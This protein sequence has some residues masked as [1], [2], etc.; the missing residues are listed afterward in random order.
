MEKIGQNNSFYV[1]PE[2]EGA[3]FMSRYPETTKMTWSVRKFHKEE[4]Y[5]SKKMESNVY[6][7]GDVVMVMV[8]KV[9]N[10][11]R[12]YTADNKFL[13]LYKGD[14]IVGTL[15]Y[16]YASDAFHANSIDLSN[17]HLLTNSG[18]IGTV[19][20]RHSETIEPTRLKLIGI[21]SDHKDFEPI[22]L[23]SALFKPGK[24]GLTYP[25]VIFVIGTGMNSGKTTTTARIGHS[26]VE[27]GLSVSLLKV[28]GSVAYRD[29]FE[30][31]STGA[32][33]TADFSDYGFPS[34]YMC[35]QE[36]LVGL[37]SRMLEDTLSSKPDVILVEIADGILQRETQLLLKSNLAKSTSVGVI[38]TAP[39][40]CSALTLVGKVK[41]L[42]YS[43]IAVSGII[44][45]SPLFVEEFATYDSTPVLDTNGNRHQFVDLI[46]RRLEIPVLV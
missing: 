37:Y 14:I 35:P 16:R 4:L 3:G 46:S 30:F 19:T 42:N 32:R 20:S 31:E 15:G 27:N 8:T 44:T 1:E 9:A 29:L 28:T 36:E 40:A 17:L 2:K 5:V 24:K 26:L 23:K 39:C 25:P 38:L 33:Y 21:V 10:H 43:P 18:L 7:A 11:T 13:R 12:I 41:E 6:E 45:N 34:T 22:N